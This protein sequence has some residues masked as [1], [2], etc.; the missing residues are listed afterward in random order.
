MADNL[1]ITKS[2]TMLI[3]SQQVSFTALLFS[4]ASLFLTTITDLSRY[5]RSAFMIRLGKNVRMAM[6]LLI[7][8][9][10]SKNLGMRSIKKYNWDSRRS[11]SW[12][13]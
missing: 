2:C 5:Y 3:N 7:L 1:S 12:M 10:R 6:N 4:F 11:R 13:D 8:L 9:D